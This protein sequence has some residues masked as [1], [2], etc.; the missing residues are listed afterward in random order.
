[1]VAV[2]SETVR[3]VRAAS[4]TSGSFQTVWYHFSVKLPSGMV[5]NL[6]ELNEKITLNNMGAKINTKTSAR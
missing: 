5:G 4:H 3:L 1:M 2:D 6:S